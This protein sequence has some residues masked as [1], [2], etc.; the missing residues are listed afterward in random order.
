MND[1]IKLEVVKNAL[2]N[3]QWVET[4]NGVLGWVLDRL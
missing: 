4:G 2:H 1:D 3:L